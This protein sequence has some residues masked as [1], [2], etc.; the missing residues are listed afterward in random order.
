M[1]VCAYNSTSGKRQEDPEV[2]LPSG[3]KNE[4]QVQ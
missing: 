1:A 2:S 4:L 3:A